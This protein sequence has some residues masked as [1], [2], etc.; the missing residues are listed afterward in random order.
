MNFTKNVIIVIIIVLIK[1]RKDYFF[2]KPAHNEYR[3]QHGAP[4]MKI[5][6][7]LNKMAQEWAEN[8]AKNGDY[9]S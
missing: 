5:N 6:D 7:K 9:F 1:K 8:C 4:P 2:W 3:A